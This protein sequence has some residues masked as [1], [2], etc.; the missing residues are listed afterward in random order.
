MV[1]AAKESLL[2][3]K[4]VDGGIHAKAGKELLEECR[5]IGGCSPG[6]AVMTQAYNLQNSAIIH[7]VGPRDGNGSIL[8]EC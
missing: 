1:N 4:G 8:E 3:G 6:E 7:T 2:G 5:R